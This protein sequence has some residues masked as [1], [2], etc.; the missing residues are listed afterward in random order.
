[1][2]HVPCGGS[3]GL[4]AAPCLLPF[5]H[6]EPCGAWTS[7][8][9]EEVGITAWLQ[10]AG[11]HL[12]LV[13][14]ARVAELLELGKPG[15]VASWVAVRDAHEAACREA[16][17][18]GLPVRDVALLHHPGLV[19]YFRVFQN[20]PWCHASARCGVDLDPLGRGSRRC[21]LAEGHVGAHLA[22][23]RRASR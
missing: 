8:P 21:V 5:G 10:W 15:N 19:K 7:E 13:C 3:F 16:L 22:S 6:A 11:S 18:D 1:M 9:P 4:F 14:F 12:H 23:R 20:G 2:A 17:E